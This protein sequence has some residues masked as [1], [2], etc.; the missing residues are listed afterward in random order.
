M[1]NELAVRLAVVGI[2]LMAVSF[3]GPWWMVSAQGSSLSMN[4]W[5]TTLEFRLLSGT[6][7]AHEAWTCCYPNTT[8]VTRTTY[9]EEPNISFV[10]QVASWLLICAILSGIGMAALI[11]VPS[12]RPIG[13]RL[14]PILGIMS[15][16]LAFVGCLCVMIWLPRAAV[17]DGSVLSATTGFWGSMSFSTIH[18][19][20][21]SSWGAGWCWYGALVAAGFF[22][23][24]SLLLFRAR[25][26]PRTRSIHDTS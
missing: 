18:G 2:I 20:G 26:P 9:S 1:R 12:R 15:S 3:L 6:T 10:L 17:Q 7:I 22:F 16:A 21:T 13:E 5:T 19:G 23:L 25:K 24:G 8:T 14:A 4:A 11:A